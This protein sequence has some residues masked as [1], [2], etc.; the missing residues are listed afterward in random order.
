V[1]DVWNVPSYCGITSDNTV[2]HL[3]AEVPMSHT[4][5]TDSEVCLFCVLTRILIRI[6]SVISLKL[7]ESR[8]K[9]KR[10]VPPYSLMGLSFQNCRL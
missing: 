8:L 9:I 10:R 7:M 3:D 5:Q 1:C 6:V 2:L 4:A